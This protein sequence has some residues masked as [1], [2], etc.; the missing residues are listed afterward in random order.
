MRRLWP[1]LTFLLTLLELQSSLSS[2]ESILRA[3]ATSCFFAGFTGKYG[4]WREFVTASVCFLCWGDQR[5]TQSSAGPPDSD[6]PLGA[7]L[8]RLSTLVVR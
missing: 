6:W 5:L 3:M 4:F 2:N 7:T 1:I 8:R